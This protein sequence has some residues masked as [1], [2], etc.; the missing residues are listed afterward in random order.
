MLCPW[1]W[2]LQ[3]LE[4]GTRV[5]LRQV[6][7][8]DEA[9][10]SLLLEWSLRTL[11]VKVT[12]SCRGVCVCVSVCLCVSVSL[13]LCVSVSLCLCVSVSLCLC[14]SVSLCLCVSVSLCLCVSVC[15]CVC[16][17]VLVF[18]VAVRLFKQVP[19]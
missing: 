11:E 16:V 8:A 14:V 1:L 4:P 15:V 17:C 6:L 9:P 19:Q 18:R 13:C 12:S 5:E 3:P 2:H 7:G 10:E